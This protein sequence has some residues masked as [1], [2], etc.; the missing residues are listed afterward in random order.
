MQGYRSPA[1][2]MEK[3]RIIHQNWPKLLFFFFFFVFLG[4]HQTS[5]SWL[6]NA[7]LHGRTTF[8]LSIHLLLDT[9][10]VSAFEL[11]WLMLL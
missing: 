1:V 11:L 3:T 9:P 10:V 5:F 6:N 2:G 7:P 4:P 8:C